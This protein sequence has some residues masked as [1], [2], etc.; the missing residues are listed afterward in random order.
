MTAQSAFPL[1]RNFTPD[2]ALPAIASRW[3]NFFI[4]PLFSWPCYDRKNFFR[5]PGRRFE[6]VW[7]PNT[8]HKVLFSSTFRSDVTREKNVH[9]DFCDVSEWLRQ[10]SPVMRS[11]EWGRSLQQAEEIGCQNSWDKIGT[12]LDW[13]LKGPKKT[14]ALRMWK[15]TSRTSVTAD[16]L[17]GEES[18]NGDNIFRISSG[19][20]GKKRLILSLDYWKQ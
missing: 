5:T 1:T 9:W 4:S 15:V 16:S 8:N 12:H 11:H 17:L 7:A 2:Y 18:Q 19:I 6:K 20:W 10:D 3:I 14:G 13:N